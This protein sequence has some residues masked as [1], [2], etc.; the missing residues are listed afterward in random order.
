QGPF[1]SQFMLQPTFLGAQ[2]LTQQLQRFLSVS[3]GGADF[4][5]SVHEYMNVESGFVPTGTLKYDKKYRFIRMGRD[6]AAYTHVDALH[7]AY[8]VALLV[9]LGVGA[10][11]N[12][13]NPY[14][15]SLTE[16]GFGTLGGP[17]TLA[18]IPEMAT[19]ALKASWFH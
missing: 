17:D 12:P 3:E 13:G 9:L 4:M 1:I 14:I 11:F 10:P 8:F 16:H 6:L 18:T 7:Q 5:T 15:G 19:R 2:P